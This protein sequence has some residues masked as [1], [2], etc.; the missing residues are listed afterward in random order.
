MTSCEPP[1]FTRKMQLAAYMAKRDL[2]D[3]QVAR[4][5]GITSVSVSRY[6]R[7][8]RIPEPLIM[9]RIKRW[10]RGAVT[11]D[12]CY[13]AYNFKHLRAPAPEHTQ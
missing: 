1:W 10:S 12:D 2:N 9:D 3:I 4:K 7:G 13:E 8:D 5:L 11:A 6:R